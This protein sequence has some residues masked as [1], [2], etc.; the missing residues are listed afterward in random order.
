MR[1]PGRACS[2][3][4]ICGG[5]GQPWPAKCRAQVRG[6]AACLCTRIKCASP[7]SA[8]PPF[9][10]DYTHARTHARSLARTFARTYANA[11]TCALSLSLSFPLSLSRSRSR[12][13]AP[14]SLARDLTRSCFP[15]RSCSFARAG[16]LSLAL[17]FWFSRPDSLASVLCETSAASMCSTDTEILAPAHHS[18]ECWG[19]EVPTAA[20]PFGCRQ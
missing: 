7:P 9:V 5:K 6:L 18:R 15:T 11:R 8:H 17:L 10:S 19:T 14:R 2:E 3:F 20:E 1:P 12:S 13:R 4:T 16:S